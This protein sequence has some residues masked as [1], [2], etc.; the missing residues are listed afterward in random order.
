VE[1]IV[2]EL[3]EKVDKLTLQVLELEKQLLELKNGS[4]GTGVYLDGTPDYV[5]EYIS[6]EGEK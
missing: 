2:K 1:E 3:T 6:K 4:L 5:K